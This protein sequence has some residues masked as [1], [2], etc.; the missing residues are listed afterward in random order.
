MAQTKFKTTKRNSRRCEMCWMMGFISYHKETDKCQSWCSHCRV[1][2]HHMSLC[3]KLKFCH[4]CGKA[5]HN[6]YRCWA[7]STITDWLQR[8][9]E[10]DRCVDCLHP[11]KAKSD[12]YNWVCG[13]CSGDNCTGKRAKDYFPSRTPKETK[14]SQTEE[15]SFI[16]QECQAELQQAKAIIENQKMQ[17]EELN[18]KITSLEDKLENC[19]TTID[20]LNWKLQCIIKEKEQ[21]LNKVNELDLLCKQK[22]IELR[23]LQEQIGKRDIELE[24]YRGTNA[25]PYQTIPATPQQPSPTSNHLEHIK[26]TNCTK[27]MLADLQD[28]QQKLSV[29]VKLLYNKVMTQDMSWH[30]YSSFIPYMGPYDTG[31]YFNKLQQV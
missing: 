15:N 20:S 21:E 1:N 18:S 5:G 22:E 4:L 12:E 2:G 3:Y 11:W 6:P 9:R 29:I 23:K 25:Q 10:E 27:A 16:G 13:Y 24:Q 19:N 14:E 8:A 31:Q 26:E 17:I 28:Q 30:N 7:Y